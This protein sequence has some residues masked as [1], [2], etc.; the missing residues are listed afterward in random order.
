MSDEHIP[1][2]IVGAGPVG[3]A[4]AYVLGTHGVRSIVCDQFD[5][6]NPHPRAHVVNTRSM[7]LLRHWGVYDEIIEDAVDLNCGLSFVWKHTVS[8]AEFGRIDLADAPAE[9]LARRLGASPVTVGSCAQDRVQRRL[10]EAVYRQGM[11]DVRYGARVTSVLDHGD[12][13]DVRVETRDGEKRFGADYVVAAE[14]ASGKIR[15]GLGIDVEGIPEFGRQINV[16]FHADLSRWTDEDPALLFWVLNTACPGV[17][18]RMGGNRWTFN[19]GFDPA[20]ESVTDYTV[21][22]C[23][24]LI[25]GGVGAPDLEVDVRSVGTWILGASTARQYRKGRIFLAG[26]AAHQFPPTGGLGMNT[27]LVDADNLGWKLAAVLNGWGCE[28]LLDTYESERRPV[29]VA[30]AESSVAN[31]MKMADAGIGPN[32]LDVAARLESSDPAV[33]AA[34]RERLAK[35]VPAQR[36]HFDYLELEIG[37]VYGVGCPSGTGADPL[38]VAVPGGR[39]PHA[40]IN[41]N[42]V[43]ISTHDLLI[44]GF[45]LITGRDGAAWGHALVEI[46]TKIPVQVCVPRRDFEIAGPGLCG[47]PDTGAILVRPDGHIAWRTDSSSATAARDLAAA[48][49]SACGATSSVS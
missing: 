48:L 15:R 9:H 29:A 21:E 36:P 27:G 43:T 7:E 30:N 42:G 2:L 22:R 13:V 39:L 37:Y 46:D 25:R 8:G 31:A 10:L 16:Y 5:G 35:S 6:I 41:R 47:I 28:T 34:E 33:A 24:E 45:T 14:G 4:T 38:T 11:A 40:W 1:V 17:F 23:A 26:D 19:F 49:D 44:P 18:I 12:S 32:T 20:R 3:L